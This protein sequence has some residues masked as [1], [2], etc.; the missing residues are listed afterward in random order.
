[1]RDIKEGWG[2][3]RGEQD[4]FFLPFVVLLLPFLVTTIIQLIIIMLLWRCA[5]FKKKLK[6]ELRMYLCL[7]R[8]LY[9][10]LV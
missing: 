6:N 4:G 2:G 7:W 10:Y 5:E 3:W 9:L 1:M 8:S